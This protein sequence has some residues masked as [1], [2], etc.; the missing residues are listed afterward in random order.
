M[1]WGRRCV[2]LA[3]CWPSIWLEIQVWRRRIRTILWKGLRLGLLRIWR[4]FRGFSMWLR[5]WKRIFLCLFRRELKHAWN[6][7]LS[8]SRLFFHRGSTL[9]WLGCLDGSTWFLAAV[10]G[11]NLRTRL[12]ATLI[13]TRISAGSVKVT[14]SPSF[15]GHRSM[16][17]GWSQYSLRF[18]ER[19]KKLNRSSLRL[20]SSHTAL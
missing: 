7:R 3:V 9:C 12:S 5:H 16:L 14:F 13:T 17:S 1:G 20:R 4:G 18:E 11:T 6:V 8:M 15:S 19:A 10:N 2:E